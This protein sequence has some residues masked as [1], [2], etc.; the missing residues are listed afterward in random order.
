MKKFIYFV[1]ILSLA[2][3]ICLFATSCGSNAETVSQ[4]V[5]SQGADSQG[6]NSQKEDS[7]GTDSQSLN[8][9]ELFSNRDLSWE[10]DESEC[11]KV[12]LADN[13]STSNSKGVEIDGNVVTITKEGIYILSGT[14]SDGMIIVD[15][16]KTQ[17]IQLVL[18]GVNINSADS[19]AIYVK[20]A[21]KVF[22][23]LADGSENILSNGGSFTAIDDN[24][25][26]A[27]IFSKDDLTLNGKGS[28]NIVLSADNSFSKDDI[29]IE[30]TGSLTISSPAGHG[31]VSKDE[32]VIT[33]GAYYIS[34]LSHGL[35]GKDIVAIA[36]GYFEIDAGED[37]IHSVNN[38]DYSV[39]NI[40]IGDGVYDLRAKSDGISAINEV[41][42]EGGS[43]IIADSYEGIEG[44]IINISDGVI[45]LNA[46]DDGI[47]ATDKREN[48]DDNADKMQGGM[49]GDVQSD[50]SI[51]ISGGVTMI[52]A[53]GD[54]LDSNGYITVTGGEVYV[55][56]SS[57]GQDGA[58]DYGIDASISG[59]IVVAAGQ[60]NMAQNFGNNSAQGSILVN[61]NTQN[62]AGSDIVLLDKDGN[63]LVEWTIGKSYNSVVVSCK[64]IADK[65]SYTLMTGDTATEVTMDG[66]IYG[67]GFGT[68]GG[69]GGRGGFG[70][71]GGMGGFNGGER[72]EGFREFDGSELP[73]DFREFDGGEPP[74]DFREFDGSEPPEDFR[75]FDGSE[76]PEDF[77]RFGEGELPEGFGH[78]PQTESTE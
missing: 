60:S 44:R 5:N 59:G 8:A 51:N 42:I 56:G 10:Y 3:A 31:I 74:E 33:G 41:C 45:S 19:A 52:N 73:E 6:T 77:K 28:Y 9:S 30:G 61:T 15:T 20:K 27:V 39:G 72:P 38:D 70:G 66:L 53:E 54:G 63:T 13:N 58:L 68:P 35:S 23:T 48:A 55:A 22:I 47:N 43:I 2:I 29:T 67:G 69:M 1:K 37:A 40:Y 50:A 14:L 24:N 65:E 64:E 78:F 75:E 62:A 12:E 4:E 32:L 25:I 76:P 46:S 71:H 16:D 7:Q 18:N 26:D 49:M 34:A 11:E 57:G 21:D 36:D 17:K